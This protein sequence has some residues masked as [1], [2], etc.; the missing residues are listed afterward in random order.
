MDLS[1]KTVFSILLGLILFYFLM[2]FALKF[3]PHSKIIEVKGDY[4]K[5]LEIIVKKIEDCYNSNFS[6]TLEK[7]CFIIR[8]QSTREISCNDF[9]QQ[10]SVPL[11]CE[12][13]RGKKGEIVIIYGDKKVKIKPVEIYE[14]S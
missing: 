4:E 7:E 14:V 2:F 11:Y 10:T 6:S 5:V 8:F 3:K 12:N 1:L 9:F 13:V